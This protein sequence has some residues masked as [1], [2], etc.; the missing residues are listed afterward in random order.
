MVPG[1]G[2]LTFFTGV[3]GER[4]VKGKSS[5]EGL[6]IP[7]RNVVSWSGENR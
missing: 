1:A 5:L 2:C 4:R 7:G 3:E 6:L